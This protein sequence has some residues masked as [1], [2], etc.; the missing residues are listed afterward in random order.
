MVFELSQFGIGIKTIEL[1][2][3][4]TDFFTDPSILVGIQRM[5]PS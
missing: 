1:G 3:M 2:G 4:K 5:T